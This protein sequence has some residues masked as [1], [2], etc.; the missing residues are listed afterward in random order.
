MERHDAL[1]IGPDGGRNCQDARRRRV[2][3]D[4]GIAFVSQHDEVVLLGQRDEIAQVLLARHRSLRVRRRAEVAQRD[5]VEH[6]GRQRRVVGQEPRSGRRRR[7]DR[8]GADRQR[9]CAIRLVERVRH[10]HG[11]PRAVLCL[12][13]ERERRVEQALARAVQ[14][15]DPRVR[16]EPRAVPS[17]DP[18]GDGRAQILG[19]V[20]GRIAAELVEMRGDRLGDQRR[21]RMPRLADRHR[22]FRPARRMAVEQPPQTR[23]RVFRQGS[24]PL[25]TLHR[26]PRCGSRL[27]ASACGVQLSGAG[28][29]GPEV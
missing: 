21:Q 14:R 29:S 5:A 9:S 3:P 18:V 1:G 17:R 8:L 10:Q 20:I 19:P 28:P 22:Q 12:R 2:A 23:K 13:R 11:G 6:R 27:I 16:V 4:L 15:H 24:E 25:G 7:L 26:W